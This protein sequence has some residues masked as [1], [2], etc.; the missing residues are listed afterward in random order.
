ML[1]Y[2]TYILKSFLVRPS[3]T[4]AKPNIRMGSGFLYLGKS[5][6][7]RARSYILDIALLLQFYDLLF[8]LGTL[9]AVM[10]CAT[11]PN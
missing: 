5:L 2:C 3:G 8:G 11:I 10:Q 6:N 9:V 1:Y 4:L 7:R